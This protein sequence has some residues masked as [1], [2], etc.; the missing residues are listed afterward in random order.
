MAYLAEQTGGFAILNNNDLGDGLARAA[1]DV[2]DYYV[3]GYAPGTKTFAG[4]GETPEYHKIAVRVKRPGLKIKTR[5]EFLGVSDVDET[6]AADDSPAQQ[7]V[8]AAISPFTVHRHR[9]ARDD[10][11]RLRAAS[12]LVRPRAAA[13]RRQLADVRAGCR[14][15]VGGGGRR[16]RDGV[17]PRRHRS[18]ASE[19]RVRRGADATR[20]CRTA[21][22]RRR[23]PTRCA[24]RFRAPGPYQVPVRRPRSCLAARSAP[25]GEFVDLPDIA[26]G[27]FA[28]SG[29]VLRADDRSASRARTP[30][31]SS[32]SPSQAVRAMRPG[33]RTEVRVRDLQRRRPGAARC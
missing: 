32:I 12:R 18:R 21:L 27:A 31:A 1:A 29:I 17:R 2:R 8:D 33:T 22:A 6:A 30:I 25:A 16:A 19:H 3:I 26:H 20:P 23:S 11:A 10:A 13:H 24:S 5:K 28:I 9:A 15:Q 7:L 4:K 14:R